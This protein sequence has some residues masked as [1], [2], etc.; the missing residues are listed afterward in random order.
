MEKKYFSMSFQS[1]DIKKIPELLEMSK[2]K[3]KILRSN[4]ESAH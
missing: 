2:V 4:K 3:N 1:L